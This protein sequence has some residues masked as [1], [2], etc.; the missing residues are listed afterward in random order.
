MPTLNWIPLSDWR[1]L[2]DASGL[3]VLRHASGKEYVGL[4]TRIR[5]RVRVH[6]NANLPYY[7]HRALRK[8]GVN[9]FC[10]AVLHLA[11]KQDLADLEILAIGLRGT[12][13]PDGFNTTR[14]GDGMNAQIWT[15][16]ARKAAADRQRVRRASPETRLR[17]SAAGKGKRLGIKQP[18]HAVLRQSLLRKGVP[19]R[20][21]TAETRKKISV[22]L[23]GKPQPHN[24]GVGNPMAGFSRGKAPRARAVLCWRPESLTPETFD[25]VADAAEAFGVVSPQMSVWAAGKVRPRSG[26]VFAYVE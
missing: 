8:F 26:V 19:T 4:S 5:R 18:A 20:P 15:D 22:A 9:T 23:T 13:A 2:P 10:V 21:P 25:C 17:M 12:Y 11:P 7:L 3:Y 24:Q 14:G 16:E 6:A 1:Q